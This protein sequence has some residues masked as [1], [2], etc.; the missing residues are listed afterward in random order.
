MNLFWEKIYLAG[1]LT[2]YTMAAIF[3]KTF[4]YCFSFCFFFQKECNG[5][6]SDDASYWIGISNTDIKKKHKK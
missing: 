4:F 6:I 3:R 2:K 5:V 1:Y